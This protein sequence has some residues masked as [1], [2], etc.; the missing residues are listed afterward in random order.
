MAGFVSRYLAPLTVI[1]AAPIVVQ[2]LVQI[3]REDELDGFSALMLV[4]DPFAWLL[5][6]IWLITCASLLMIPFDKYRGRPSPGHRGPATEYTDNCG[7]AYMTETGSFLVF[8]SLFIHQSLYVY[9]NFPYV[10]GAMFVVTLA[11]SV[12]LHRQAKKPKEG[13]DEK[14]TATDSSAPMLYELCHGVDYHPRLLDFDI[15]QWTTVRIGFLSWQVLAIVFFY[16]AYLLQGF[17]WGHFVTTLLLTYYLAKSSVCE[18]AYLASMDAYGTKP[19][20]YLLWITMNLDPVVYT[21]SSHYFVIHQ[22]A[23]G[24]LQNLGIFLLGFLVTYTKFNI[25]AQ[26]DLFKMSRGNCLIRGRKAT[27]VE[28]VDDGETDKDRPRPRLLTSGYWGLARHPHY[29]FEILSAL[30]WGLPGLGHGFWPFLPC[31]Y[32]TVTVVYRL[33]RDEAKCS[34]KYGPLWN[35]YCKTVKYRL[36]PYVF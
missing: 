28:A 11:L 7:G 25:E 5:V 30:C 23:L 3:C 15:K 22:P 2:Y 24:F 12:Y 36:I 34:A 32:M 14:A 20:F 19:G 6:I 4:G 9:R 17:N 31:L 26:K 21:F 27:Y 10:M 33:F 13:E 29:V 16:A 35:E 18:R 1:V 8:H